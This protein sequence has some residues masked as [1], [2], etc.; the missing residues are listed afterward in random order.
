MS[1]FQSDKVLTSPSVTNKK[2]EVE[3]QSRLGPNQ[4]RNQ[5]VS[6]CVGLRLSL[7]ALAAPVCVC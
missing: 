3:M 1:G 2:P 5:L 4:A 7:G 6:G